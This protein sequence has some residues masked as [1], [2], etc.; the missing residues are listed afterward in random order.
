[1]AFSPLGNFDPSAALPSKVLNAAR[2]Y[3]A[4]LPTLEVGQSIFAINGHW[5]VGHPA[6]DFEDYNGSVG[7]A[8]GEFFLHSPHSARDNAIDASGDCSA[9]YA[10][11]TWLRN[12]GQFGFSLDGMVG[13]TEHNFGTESDLGVASM[14]WFCA[15]VAAVAVKY[16]VDLAG[17]KPSAAGRYAGEPTFLTH[18]ECAV[19]GGKPPHPDWYNYGPSG[20]CER[21]DFASLVA[22]P[23]GMS[24]TDEMATQVGDALRA[25]GHRYKVA[26]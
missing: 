1:M 7:C 23:E 9:N 20:R 12:A 4:S 15:G 25:L 21:W 19:R 6:Q 14:H 17:T 26:I 3:L 5:T 22:L 18:A 13:A 10:A 11:H 8:D 24:V 2:S 16:G